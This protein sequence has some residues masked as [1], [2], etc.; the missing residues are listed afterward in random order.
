MSPTVFGT[1]AISTALVLLLVILVF[2][3]GTLLESL[4]RRAAAG[5][6]AC[7]EVSAITSCREHQDYFNRVLCELQRKGLQVLDS[8][9]EQGWKGSDATLVVR[10]Q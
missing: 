1:K 8:A 3:S 10:S 4:R 7:A 5:G 9:T 6:S 2:S